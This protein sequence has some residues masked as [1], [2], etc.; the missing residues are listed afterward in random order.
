[1]IHQLVADDEDLLKF[2]ELAGPRLMVYEMT[3]PTLIYRFLTEG[4]S[5][6]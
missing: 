5:S 3:L 2:L 4:A 6:I 1:V